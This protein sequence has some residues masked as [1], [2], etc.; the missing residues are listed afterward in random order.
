M[1][2]ETQ[3]GLL[4]APVVEVRSVGFKLFEARTEDGMSTATGFTQ[5]GAV[6]NLRKRLPQDATLVVRL[7]PEPYRPEEFD[8]HPEDELEGDR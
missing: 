6:A 3:A 1:A 2:S 4:W 7:I 8:L 5:E